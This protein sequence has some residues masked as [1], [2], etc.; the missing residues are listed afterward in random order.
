[1]EYKRD[2]LSEHGALA[3]IGVPDALM[4]LEDRLNEVPVKAGCSKSTSFTSLLDPGSLAVLGET[5][6]QTLLTLLDA[7]VGP[8]QIG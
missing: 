1:M 6:V 5:I 3:V 2:V 7:P 4:W 8:I